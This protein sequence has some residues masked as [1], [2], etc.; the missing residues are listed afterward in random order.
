MKTIAFIF[1]RGGSKGLPGKNIKP[2]NGKPLL[3]YSIETALKVPQIHDVFVST[4]CDVIAGVAMA[5]GVKVIK[6]PEELAT[7][8]SPEWLSWR[9]AIEYVT[10]KYGSFDRFV[11]LPATSPLRNEVDVISALEKLNSTGADICISVTPANRSPYFNM[12]KVTTDDSVEIV[13]QPEGSVSRRQD[14][15]EVFDI[16]TVVYAST[17]SFI[18]EQSSI[19]SGKVVAA[20]IPK[21]RAVDIDDIYD[22]MFA[23]AVLKSGLYDS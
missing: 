1:A 22:F 8:T 13:I 7:D 20:V 9:H 5:C 12:V 11:S 4:D 6:R 16:T 14:A 10:E 19:F 15:P 2:L 17:V 21:I 3:Q 23:E 18:Q